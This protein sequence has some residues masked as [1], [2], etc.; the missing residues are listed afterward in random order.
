MLET[1]ALPQY[2]NAPIHA[3]RAS[4]CGTF[5]FGHGRIEKIP[6]FNVFS[7]GDANVPDAAK[8]AWVTTNSP[9]AACSPTPSCCPPDSATTIFRPDLFAQAAQLARSANPLNLRALK[10]SGHW[11]TLLTAFL[12]FDFSFMV[13]TLL[14]PLGAQIGE[15]LHLT[16]GSRKG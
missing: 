8:A 5:D 10:S 7:G 3:L 12:Y 14:G 1:L 11:P 4:M 15:T 2:V 13:W 16:R 9:P 6:D